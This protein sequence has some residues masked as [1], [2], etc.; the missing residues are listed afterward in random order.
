MAELTTTT[1]QTLQLGHYNNSTLAWT[2]TATP[3]LGSEVLVRTTAMRFDLSQL[4]A[5][6]L[7]SGTLNFTLTL[8]S[9]TVQNGT[10]YALTLL[11]YKGSTAETALSAAFPPPLANFT[12]AQTVV[13][14]DHP[15]DSNWMFLAVD[16][17]SRTTGTYQVEISL[18]PTGNGSTLPDPYYRRLSAVNSRRYSPV[19][20]L[21]NWTGHFHLALVG[22][23]FGLGT[24]TVTAP[25]LEL[26][27]LPFFSGCAGPGW[28]V[29]G[30][31]R[32]VRDHRFGMPILSNKLIR[33]GDNPGLWVRASDWDPEDPPNEYV[34]D[35]LEGVVDDEI[36]EP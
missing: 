35:P 13:G 27:W 5:P 34:P 20:T 7:A 17:T 22:N 19:W 11:G 21:K 32:A 28:G 31:V 30:R 15:S 26:E 10:R 3:D 12:L 29:G 6:R 36:G 8:P 1:L 25:T 14:N 33:D 23:V 4:E 18:F 9:N 16:Q 24:V 2:D